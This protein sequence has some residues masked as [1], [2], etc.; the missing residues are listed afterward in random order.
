[1]AMI[2]ALKR[3]R[4]DGDITQDDVDEIGAGL[5]VT[6]PPRNVPH[7]Y[8]NNYTVRLT[9]A[10]NY[11]HDITQNGTAGPTQIFRMNSIF[12]PDY[13]GAGHQPHLRDLWASQ[14][15]YYTVLSCEYQIRLY[16]ASGQDPVTY[17]AV[18]S[19]AQ[20]IGAVNVAF[21]A[22]TNVN[23][24][25]TPATAGFAFPQL[26]MKNVQNEFLVPQQMVSFTGKLSQGDF[27]MDASQ[28]DSDTTWTA[29]GANPAVV[30]YFG[31]SIT[32]AQWAAL[33]GVNETPNTA[34]QSQVILNYTVQFTQVAAG[35]RQVNS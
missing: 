18:G 4:T 13:T 25:I 12:D 33:V 19:S 5:P 28:A 6:N 20:T 3:P 2:P 35:Y 29:V 1:M 15:E 32:P 27:L 21:M 26:E 22:T 23:D 11:R 10:D 8:N 7:G 16:N 17:T 14:Y 30:R 31:Y 34:I 9:Y 24:L